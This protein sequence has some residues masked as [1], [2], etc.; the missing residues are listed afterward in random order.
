MTPWYTQEEI[1]DMCDGLEQHAAQIRYLRDLGL[2]VQRKPN[3][4]P[5]LL[6]SHAE[7]V[8]AGAP[9][10]VASAS[11]SAAN[12]GPDTGALISF[13]AARQVKRGRA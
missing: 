6:R 7:L 10:V 5:L 1:N 4:R 2:R 13:L 8:L 12:T 11:T 9:E 3:G